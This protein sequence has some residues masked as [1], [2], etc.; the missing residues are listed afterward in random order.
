MLNKFK[1]DL[2]SCYYRVNNM[3][4]KESFREKMRKYLTTHNV[5]NKETSPVQTFR[6]LQERDDDSQTYASEMDVSADPWKKVS[7]INLWPK[8]GYTNTTI[9][10]TLDTDHFTSKWSAEPRPE[11]LFFV[12]TKFHGKYILQSHSGEFPPLGA[13][14]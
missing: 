14:N 6:M 9:P 3:T 10:K 5:T 4:T 1:I 12:R 7:P 2:L 13:G 11:E 8:I